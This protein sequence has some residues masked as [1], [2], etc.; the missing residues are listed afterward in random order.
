[1]HLR[2]TVTG[3]TNERN[4]APPLLEE[5]RCRFKPALLI[6][7]RD[8]NA[9]LTFSRRAPPNEVSAPLDQLLELRTVLR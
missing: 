2:I 6:V 5:M 1:M 7:R 3:G 8:R 9:D 4:S